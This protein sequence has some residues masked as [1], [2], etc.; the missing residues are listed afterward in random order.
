M[1]CPS[2]PLLDL[3]LII[4]ARKSPKAFLEN[5]DLEYLSEPVVFET[6]PDFN[7]YLCCCGILACCSTFL[8]SAFI[9]PV[10]TFCPCQLLKYHELKLQKD[11]VKFKYAS[12]DCCCHIAETQRTV[13]LE[14]I[15]DVSLHEDW[16]MTCC[17]LKQLR[18]E[19]AGQGTEGPE[20]AAA[21]LKFPDQAR[22]CVQLA[23]KLHQGATTSGPKTQLMMRG[24]GTLLETRIEQLNQLVDL[25]VMS[26]QKAGEVRV[27]VLAADFDVTA[28]LV[29]ADG[30][31]KKGLMTPKE[32]DALRDRLLSRVMS[33][34]D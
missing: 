31:V 7:K 8:T 33:S 1:R 11:A 13:P 18:I 16:V 21:F 34:L 17:G 27:A 4:M 24:A 25:G 12:N 29:E 15:Q 6:T 30:L 23:V 22:D 9:C 20:I 3:A 28:R 32:L 10:S 14:K 5:H 26:V 19:T 2:A